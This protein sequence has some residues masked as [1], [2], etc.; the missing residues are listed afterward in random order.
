[1]HASCGSL[2]YI[3]PPPPL[4]PPFS[5]VTCPSS[6]TFPLARPIRFS[7]CSC[8]VQRVILSFSVSKACCIELRRKQQLQ[9]PTIVT[10]T[11]AATPWRK[12]SVGFANGRPN[13]RPLQFP[14]LLVD[15]GCQVITCTVTWNRAMLSSESGPPAASPSPQSC[16]RRSTSRPR[17]RSKAICARPSAIQLQ[18]KLR[19]VGKGHAAMPL[20]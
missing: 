5:P 1:M 20:P 10:A 13:R 19:R 12:I 11:P 16:S 4:G 6:Y 18:C 3:V 17:T 14:E 7:L 15:G 2:L 9:W 8:H